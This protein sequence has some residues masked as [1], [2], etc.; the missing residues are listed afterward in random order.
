MSTVY[1]IAYKVFY[2]AFSVCFSSFFNHFVPSSLYSRRRK[3][4]FRWDKTSHP[5]SHGFGSPNKTTHQP[6]A[7]TLNLAEWSCCYSEFSAKGRKGG[8]LIEICDAADQRYMTEGR[9]LRGPSLYRTILRSW[10]PP[11]GWSTFGDPQFLYAGLSSR[12]FLEA[13]LFSGTLSSGI[14]IIGGHPR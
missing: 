12:G 3:L 6:G 8:R 2:R 13:P 7:V 5:S 1:G 14:Y 4:Q 9:W 11:R 10:Q